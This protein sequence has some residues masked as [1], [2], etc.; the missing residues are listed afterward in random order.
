MQV[1]VEQTSNLG[2]K[3]TIT[4][5]NALVEDAFD[6][7]LNELA[8][9]AKIDGFRPGKVPTRVLKM[10]Y[11]VSLREEVITEVVKNSFR[12]A[13]E[14]ESLNPAGAPTMNMV[15]QDEGV[16]VEYTVEIEVYPEITLA[17][18]SSITIEKE[19][20]AFTEKHVAERIETFR[21]QYVEWEEVER[22]SANGDRITIDFVGTIAGEEFVGGKAEGFLLELGSSS[23][24]PGFEEGL[25]NKKAG[26]MVT[27]AVPFPAGLPFRR[28]GR[29]RC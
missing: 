12:D 26:E 28:F 25:L 4:V 27:I 7:R 2:R 9:T 11:G 10:R 14:Q 1:S 17:D 16:D 18:V 8:K 5:P 29:Q 6:T 21:K 22:V 24:I 23:M 13:L 3:L 20:A 19:S 15:K